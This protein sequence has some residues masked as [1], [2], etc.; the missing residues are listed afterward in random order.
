VFRS[1][2]DKSI[3]DINKLLIHK[4][5]IHDSFGMNKVIIRSFSDLHMEFGKPFVAARPTSARE[6]LVLAGDVTTYGVA[7]WQKHFPQILEHWGDYPVIFCS[8]NH[9]YYG[10]TNRLKKS[11][12]DVDEELASWL[13][14]RFPNVRFLRNQGTTVFG[15]Q[16]FG[17]TCW[18]D[19][20]QGDHGAMSVADSQMSDFS[21][22]CY[23]KNI[24]LQPSHTIAM[25]DAF[26]K[27]LL[28]WFETDL[29]GDR[30]VVTHHS[31]FRDDN[32]CYND[33]LLN[34]A[35]VCTD[36]MEVIEKYRPK[37]WIHGHTHECRNNVSKGVVTISNQRGYPRINDINAFEC[38]NFDPEGMPFSLE[39]LE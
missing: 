20:D 39:S 13:S 8:G 3:N 38:R 15:I 27:S 37:L 32:S 23:D 10:T 6:I 14:H 21:R 12:Q 17:G 19:F 7:L 36:L 26:V 1:I 4:L 30:L 2:N 24:L 11:M 5:K 22:I 18:T 33:S 9:E 31:P 34:P 16:I 29:P 25:H 35:F 28:A